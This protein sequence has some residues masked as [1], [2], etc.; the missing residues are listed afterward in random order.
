MPWPVQLGSMRLTLALLAVIV[1]AC[2][3]GT[4]RPEADIFHAWW[5][6]ALVGA[7]AAILLACGVRQALAL[8]G[9]HRGAAGGRAAASLLLH[10]GLLTILAGAAVS[11]AVG[12][13]GT[14]DLRVGETASAFEVGGMLRPL[15][16]TVTLQHFAIETQPARMAAPAEAQGTLRVSWPGDAAAGFRPPIR[17]FRSTVMLAENG[18]MVR[19]GDVAVNAPLTWRG[20]ALYQAGYNPRD[21]AWTSLLVVHDPGVPVVYTGFALLLAGLFPL[22]FVWPKD[23]AA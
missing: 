5:F 21:P 8:R 7:L 19:Q 14:L 3:A 20:Y 2:V 1:A 13:H 11:G 4:L 15:P 23:S 18:R 6:F 17:N 9:A 10:A 16:F 22:L 12:E